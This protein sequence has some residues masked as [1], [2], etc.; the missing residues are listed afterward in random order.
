MY[1]HKYIINNIFSINFTKKLVILTVAEKKIWFLEISFFFGGI[2]VI[3]S[4]KVILS[5]NLCLIILI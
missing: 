2:S 4:L 1:I 5:L 3:L